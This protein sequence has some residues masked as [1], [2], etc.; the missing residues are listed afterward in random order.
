MT[1]FEPWTSGVGSDCC[2]NLAT[3]PMPRGIASYLTPSAVDPTRPPKTGPCSSTSWSRRTENGL[4][5]TTGGNLHED[6]DD[7]SDQKCSRVGP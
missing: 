2:T 4:T 5:F 6:D 1:R 3:Q 7:Q